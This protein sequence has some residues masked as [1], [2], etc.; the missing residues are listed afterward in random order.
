MV[1]TPP[2]VP[3]LMVVVCCAALGTEK[4]ASARVSDQRLLDLMTVPPSFT[5]ENHLAVW[6]RFSKRTFRELIA[7]K[8]TN[9]RPTWNERRRNLLSRNASLPL[10]FPLAW[11]L[12]CQI[13]RS[14]QSR[15][16]VAHA[17]TQNVLPRRQSD[18]HAHGQLLLAHPFVS[19]R[20]Q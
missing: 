9:Y 13:C 20:R 16:V 15:E 18:G 14:K 19:R 2:A 3:P 5:E 7:H 4:K 11:N 17:E 6:K 10:A 12:Q 8:L 1:L